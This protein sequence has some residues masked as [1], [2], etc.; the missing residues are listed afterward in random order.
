MAT[1][2]TET[3]DKHGRI[4]TPPQLGTPS[5]GHSRAQLVE[6]DPMLA[7]CQPERRRMLLARL[8]QHFQ[9]PD[10]SK[11]DQ[12]GGDIKAAWAA[13][14]ADYDEDLAMVTEEQLADACAAWR[15]KADPPNQFFPRPGELLAVIRHRRIAE[16]RYARAHTQLRSPDLLYV[17]PTEEE[18]A[19]AAELVRRST[20]SMGRTPQLESK[21]ELTRVEAIP[22]DA[23]RAAE[24]LKGYRLKTAA[25]CGIVDDEPVMTT[26]SQTAAVACD[27][28]T[29][30]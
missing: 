8:S 1:D 14:W 11:G 30:A 29:T 22:G 13:Y 2:T 21:P 9:L 12:L 7:L 23:K 24:A 10:L 6:V 25:E 27:V 28:S 17:P 18:K 19:R 20:A 16:E 15:R 26:A 3:P 4:A 5:L